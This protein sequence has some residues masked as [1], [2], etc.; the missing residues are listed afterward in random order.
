LL[1]GLINDILDFSKIEAGKLSLERLDFNLLKFLDDFAVTL[2]I[3]AQ[4]KGLELICNSDPNVPVMIQGDPGRL[5]QILT[6]LAGNAIKFTQNG[7]VNIFVKLLEQIDDDA[8]LHF[9]V[10]DTGIGIPED[11]IP[12]LFSKFM[13]VDTSTTRK[14]GGTG[15]GLAI[16]KQ[17]AEM[18]CGEIGVN[19]RE[20]QGSEFWFTVKLKALPVKNILDSST[21]MD[22]NTIKVLI[23]DDNSTNREIL[24]IRL[25]SWG[26]S[27]FEAE[28]GAEA[29]GMLREAYEEKKPFRIALIDMQMPGMD[30]V[31]LGGL[32]KTDQQLED[33]IMVLLTSSV[34]D[35]NILYSDIG[36]AD[37]MIKPIR[38]L[39]LKSV[40]VKLLIS[41][42]INE[43]SVK[44]AKSINT[45]IHDLSNYFTNN[46]FKLLLVED[47]A[48]NQQVALGI[49]EKFGL[50]AD[51]AINGQEA[52]DKLERTDY[53]LVLMDIQMPVMDG[54]EATRVIRDS[55][56]QVINHNVPIIAMT[57]HAMQS[58]QE[59]CL[60]EGMDDYISKPVIVN[61]LAEKLEKWLKFPKHLA[62][63]KH[64]ITTAV[65]TQ[66]KQVWDKTGMLQR[67][68]DN[69][70]IAFKVINSFL[71]DFPQQIES[72][73][74]LVSAD[75]IQN[76]S[77]Q[78]HTIKG[79]AAAVGGDVI[80]NMAIEMENA[81]K[82]GNLNFVKTN[83]PELDIQFQNLKQQLKVFLEQKNL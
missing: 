14:F 56:S 32:I 23:V 36:F 28:N 43:P 17:L 80:H 79:I 50:N 64:L 38:H 42:E 20:G 74:A 75:D 3:R 4:E 62:N 68:M 53:N 39:D 70:D 18:M 22:L 61:T 44:T 2:A 83:I 72:L 6:N 7:E 25:K 71:A 78:A 11:K 52:I 65:P 45:S 73:K 57:A 5:G 51:V 26:M 34:I 63:D 27:V 31:T 46:Q 8:I 48:T 54:F 30:G 47:N 41:R 24:N 10:K 35:N 67:L 12:L 58:D 1:L 55:H 76:I 9:S 19:S 29:L 13:Q 21:E 59:K 60:N 81:A 69:E 49:L 66:T 77:R 15:L 40:L 16:S 82:N 37:V 33:I